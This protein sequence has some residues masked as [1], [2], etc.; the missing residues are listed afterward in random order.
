MNHK[1]NVY[2][3]E[4]YDPTNKS[5]ETDSNVKTNRIYKL[6][7]SNIIGH[8]PVKQ[9]L[10]DTINATKPINLLL[11]GSPSTSKTF[12]IKTV[13]KQIEDQ[14]PNSTLFVDCATST[15]SGLSTEIERLEPQYI[16]MD[17]LESF[18]TSDRIWNRG[19]I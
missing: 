14:N 11:S 1:V 6:D 19:N 7:L 18:D 5:V 10:I 15:F 3:F 12:L 8:E 13:Q 16:F 9:T 2:G 17:E 4:F